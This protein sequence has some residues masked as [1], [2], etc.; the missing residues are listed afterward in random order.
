VVAKDAD[1]GT[2]RDYMYN[3]EVRRYRRET[4]ML[5]AWLAYV[6]DQD[7]DAIA[8]FEVNHVPQEKL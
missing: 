5:S 6:R 3:A 8:L 4:D 2:F 1:D 7:V